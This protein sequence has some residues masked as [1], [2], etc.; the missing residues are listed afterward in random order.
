MRP[1]HG[2]DTE[3]LVCL[4]IVEV[5]ADVFSMPTF[6]TMHPNMKL[7]PDEEAGEP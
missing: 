3:Y 4:R 1:L 6:R 7:F 5:I 2:I